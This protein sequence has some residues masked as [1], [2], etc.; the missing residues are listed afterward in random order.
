MADVQIYLVGLINNQTV[1][2]LIDAV[3][4]RV[5]KG[6]RSVLIA[7]SSPGGHI[8]W[9]VT[10]YNFLRGLGIQVTTHNAG[11]VDSIAGVIYCAG[12]DRMS[13]PDARFLIH[14]VSLTFPGSDP[15]LSEKD[16]RSR[17]GSLEK[18]RDTIAAILATRTGKPLDDV[19]QDM[20]TERILTAAEAKDYGF[21]T[22]ITPDVFDASQE[23]VQIVL[24]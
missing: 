5:G 17:L 23:I 12:D 22:K 8:Y 9:G 10:A 4:E 3:T 7:I 19:R 11:Q 14:G 6:A 24:P 18:E 16:L 21:V 15:T 1:P 13:V 20:L 2:R